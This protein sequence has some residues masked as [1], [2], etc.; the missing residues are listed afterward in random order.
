MYTRSYIN[1]SPITLLLGIDRL[2]P[3]LNVFKLITPR[4][5]GVRAFSSSKNGLVAVCRP[6]LAAQNS[7]RH[8]LFVLLLSRDGSICCQSPFV[9]KSCFRFGQ[10]HIV[11]R[12]VALYVRFVA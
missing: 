12:P 4:T 2:P 1:G 5:E 9:V 10:L 6:Y 7:F 3:E 11:A 8:R